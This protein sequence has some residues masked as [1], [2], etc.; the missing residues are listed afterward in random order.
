[1]Q[2]RERP[3]ERSGAKSTMGKEEEKTQKPSVPSQLNFV[4]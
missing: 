4:T 3:Q 2:S 1:M